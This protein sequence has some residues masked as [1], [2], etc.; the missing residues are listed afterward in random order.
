[1]RFIS[2]IAV[3]MFVGLA[4]LLSEL[5][6]YRRSKLTERLAPYAPHMSPAKG[7]TFLSAASFAEVVVPLSKFVGERIAKIFGVSEELSIRLTRIHSPLDVNTFRVRQVGWASAVFMLGTISAVALRLPVFVALPLVVGTPILTILLLEQQI[8][9]AS[10]AWQRALFLELPLVAEQI[11]MLMSAGWS[12]SAALQRVASRGSG[13][14]AA[15]LQRVMQRIHQGLTEIEALHEWSELASLEALD[16]LI[17]ILALNREA[18][19]LGRLISN[20]ART[21]LRETQ[22]ELIEEIEK[23]TQQVWIPV[24]FATLIPGL[25]LMGIPFLDALTLFTSP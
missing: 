25:L 24:T 16:R 18:G 23:R 1:M 14:C 13:N 19:D 5:R 6:W 12:L 21:M 3:I 15:D 8:I 22:R 10:E 11:G 20:E 17:A 2:F 9:K 4:L 7:T